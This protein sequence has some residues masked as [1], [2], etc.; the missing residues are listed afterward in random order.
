MGFPRQ[1]CWR[2]LLFPAQEDLPGP[3]TEPVSPAL[4]DVFFTTETPGKSSLSAAVTAKSLQ[5]W[6]TLCDP[7]DGSPP[8]SHSLVL[9]KFP[10]VLKLGLIQAGH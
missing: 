6:P 8:G 5:S 2:G 10:T 7:I 3:G 4:A 9:V 1:E